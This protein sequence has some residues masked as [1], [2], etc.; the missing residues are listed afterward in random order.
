MPI[1]RTIYKQGN[2]HVIS[3][4]TYMLEQAKIKYPGKVLLKVTPRPSIEINPIPPP[5]DEAPSAPKVPS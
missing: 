5:T 1:E 2:A 3:I 4:P